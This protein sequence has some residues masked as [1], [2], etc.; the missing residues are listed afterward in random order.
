MAGP[1]LNGQPGAPFHRFVRTPEDARAAVLELSPDV[2]FI[3]V[4][5]RLSRAALIAAIEE[6]RRHG[7]EVHGH[8]PLGV[9]WDE[10]AGVGMRSIEHI[11]TIPFERSLDDPPDLAEAKR[12]APRHFFQY[13]RRAHRAGV[14]I[15]AGADVAT[16]PG[17]SLLRESETGL[18]PREALESATSGPALLL[19]R[20]DLARVAPGSQATFLVVEADPLQRISALRELTLVVLR[21]RVPDQAELSRYRLSQ[22]PVAREE[23]APCHNVTCAGCASCAAHG[24]VIGAKILRW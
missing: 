16:Y 18:S 10:A 19:H 14:P 22:R 11:F 7:L 8:A 17:C 2:D 1:T 20:P 12:S 21:G 23:W 13:V 15:I 3:K 24:V 5:R 4:H 9:G 6:G